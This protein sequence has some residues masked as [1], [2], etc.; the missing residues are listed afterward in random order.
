MNT[1]IIYATERGRRLPKNRRITK[2]IGL[3]NSAVSGE[4]AGRQKFDPVKAK[5]CDKSC[6]N[7][8]DI[9]HI[10]INHEEN[11]SHRRIIKKMIGLKNSTEF[12][13]IGSQTLNSVTVKATIL[14][15]NKSRINIEGIRKVQSYD[16]ENHERNIK[17]NNLAEQETK[18]GK[19]RSV[20]KKKKFGLKSYDSLANEEEIRNYTSPVIFLANQ[21]RCSKSRNKKLINE[22]KIEKENKSYKT[23]EVCNEKQMS[24]DSKEKRLNQG[25]YDIHNINHYHQNDFKSTDAKV[26]TSYFIA[27]KSNVG[28]EVYDVNGSSNDSMEGFSKNQQLPNS[29]SQSSQGELNYDESKAFSCYDDNANGILKDSMIEISKQQQSSNHQSCHSH[30]E[31][32][33]DENNKFNEDAENS[34]EEKND[35]TFI[36]EES[37]NISAEEQ[38]LFNNQSNMLHVESNDDGN[39]DFNKDKEDSNEKVNNINLKSNTSLQEHSEKKQLSNDN[40]HISQFNHN[41]DSTNK[42]DDRNG[43]RLKKMVQLNEIRKTFKAN[44]NSYEQG[45]EIE[46]NSECMAKET[47]EQNEVND[48]RHS[49]KNLKDF[50][51]GIDPIE[52]PEN[53]SI[54]NNRVTKRLIDIGQVYDVRIKRVSF[55]DSEKNTVHIFDP[56]SES[57]F[58]EDESKSEEN[59]G[60]CSPAFS[61]L[62]IF[63]YDDIENNS[64][65]DRE[66]NF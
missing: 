62:R 57:K 59:T 22:K 29:R 44:V 28:F 65:F 6:L 41:D 42:G 37:M 66:E 64:D 58:E 46:S 39:D 53:S 48:T 13:E 11:R 60:M 36:S 17:K 32:D 56:R 12:N 19:I 1:S 31:L 21:S 55:A 26:K 16:E 30:F 33:Y 47:V 2:K 50:R 35:S 43:E 34:N 45:K 25:R 27:K 7:V 18:L 3:K 20:I 61:D 15:C 52:A 54:L 9:K 5:H 63:C 14:R 40:L 38:Q 24:K 51:V 10:G 4:N 23:I 8:E 49:Y